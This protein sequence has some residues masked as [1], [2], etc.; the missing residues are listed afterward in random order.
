[1]IADRRTDA[2]GTFAVED[3]PRG[4]YGL[5]IEDKAGGRGALELGSIQ[6]RDAAEYTAV[7]TIHE[8]GPQ[9]THVSLKVTRGRSR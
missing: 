3:V 8:W 4:P 2:D 5:V 1:M 7:A 6:F 9:A